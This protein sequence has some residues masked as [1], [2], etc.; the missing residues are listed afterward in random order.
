MPNPFGKYGDMLMRG[1]VGQAAP[2]IAQGVLVELL[3]KKKLDVKLA[4]KWV[5]GNYSLWDD[6]KPGEQENMRKLAS[7]VG[8]VSWMNFDWAVDAMREELPAVASLFL[9][10]VKA[11]NWLVRQIEEIKR[12]IA[13]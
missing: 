5:Q 7:R 10:W 1:L 4:T 8:D 11:K 2:G 13:S 6:L 9:G 12:A 3:K